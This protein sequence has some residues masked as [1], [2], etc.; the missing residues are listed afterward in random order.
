MPFKSQAQS[1]A[2]FGGYLGPA[3]QQKADQWAHETP[4]GIKALPQHVAQ[5]KAG[6]RKHIINQLSKEK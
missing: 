5:Q 2:A 4:G 1:R 6:Q 3:M